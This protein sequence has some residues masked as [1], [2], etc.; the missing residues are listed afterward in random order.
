MLF[1]R[2]LRVV[3][4]GLSRS[5]RSCG[6]TLCLHGDD[7][8]QQAVG[9]FTSDSHS[10]ARWG[11][12]AREYEECSV[13]A[14]TEGALSIRQR[15]RF[16]GPLKCGCAVLPAPIVSFGNFNFFFI[17]KNPIFEP[18]ISKHEY[19]AMHAAWIRALS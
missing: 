8:T 16:L 6:C 10:F 18:V 5:C 14:E 9:I 15:L 11:K 19:G 17:T 7:A 2:S 13:E 3:P 12:I 1:Q 4:G